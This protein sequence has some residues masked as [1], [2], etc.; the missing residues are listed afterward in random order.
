M[1]PLTF[2]V[3]DAQV[4]RYAAAPSLRLRIRARND[5]EDWIDALALRVRV[6]IEPYAR[7]YE[8]AE[9][10]RLTE[11]FGDRS[12]WG[13]AVRP[14]QWA[15]SSVTA[16]AFTRE[17]AFDVALP[18]SYDLNVASG[19]FISALESG[20]IPLRLFF[21][22]TIFRGSTTGFT[23]EML[24][25]STECTTRLALQLWQDAMNTAF[26]D[27]AWIRIDRSTFHELQR[28][29]AEHSFYTWENTFAHLLAR[30]AKEAT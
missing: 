26:P 18:C 12:R 11:V 3:V 30:E 19:K 14:L 17:T 16:G 9:E 8:S 25:W 7:A 13:H 6:Q 5:G 15:E 28:Y 20:D 24:P 23:V 21:T 10:H 22:G 29:R 2:D 4:E 27:D 1:T